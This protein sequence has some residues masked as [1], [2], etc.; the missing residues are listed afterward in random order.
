MKK[1]YINPNIKIVKIVSHAQMLAGSFEKNASGDVTG[2]SLQNEDATGS[3]LSRGFDDLD[4][5]F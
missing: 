2:G 5:D 4:D 1:T 3:G